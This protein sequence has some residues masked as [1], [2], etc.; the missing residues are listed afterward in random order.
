MNRFAGLL[1]ALLL[2]ARWRT[3]AAS[4]RG[5]VAM[6]VLRGIRRGLLLLA[7]PLGAAL[8]Q[9]TFESGLLFRVQTSSEAAPSYL[10]GTMH[11]EDPRVLALPPPVAA[12]LARAD[13]FVMEVVPDSSAMA[14]SAA[15]MRFDDGTMLADVLPQDLYAQT[16]EALGRRGI[17]EAAVRGFKPWAVLTL[18][19]VPEAETGE[20][21]DIMLYRRA[22]AAAMPVRGLESMAEQTAVLDGL[23]R[24]DQIALL[25]ETLRTQ[26]RLPEMFDALTEAYHRRDLRSL[27]ELNDSYL[28]QADPDV[29]E[30]LE[31]AL[32]HDRNARMEERVL[33]MLAEGGHFI[34]VGALHLPGEGGLLERLRRRGHAIDCVY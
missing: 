13:V 31:T 32:I 3:R 17:P 19:N 10:F 21:L 8:A 23:S 7:L 22:L 26:A 25:R 16:I 30:R 34:A 14:D 4:S 29:V 27:L 33:P 20:F 12:A 28:R 2:A 9:P 1:W 11:S 6:P 5:R 18:L 15:A 24:A